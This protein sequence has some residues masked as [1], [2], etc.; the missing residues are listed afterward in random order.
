MAITMQKGGRR[1]GLVWCA[2]FGVI[3]R[4][5]ICSAAQMD[6]SLHHEILLAL[7][8][9]PGNAFRVSKEDSSIEVG[10]T[11]MLLIF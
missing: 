7:S 3:A 10:P 2:L 8:G 5:Q 6:D 4:C 1:V 11:K 9:Y